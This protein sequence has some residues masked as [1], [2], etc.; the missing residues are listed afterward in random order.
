MLSTPKSGNPVLLNRVNHLKWSIKDLN[1]SLV[2]LRTMEKTLSGRNFSISVKVLNRD[3]FTVSGELDIVC[4]ESDPLLPL[5]RALI[6]RRA[7]ILSDLRIERQRDLQ[8][9]QKKMETGRVF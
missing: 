4:P 9:V 6:L 2:A 1:S 8:A 7:K 5:I 3:T